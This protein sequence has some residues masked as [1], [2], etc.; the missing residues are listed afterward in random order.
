M[1][2]CIVKFTLGQILYARTGGITV[3]APAK[4]GTLLPLGMLVSNPN[5]PTDGSLQQMTVQTLEELE[6]VILDMNGQVSHDRRPGGNT[7]KRFTVWKWRGELE[8]QFEAF[9]S[10]GIGNLLG[11]RGPREKRGTFFYLR[12][13]YL[14][15]K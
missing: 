1:P 3:V 14:P 15:Q 6:S 2:V 5:P 10:G 4:D 13:A 12:G 8:Q 9:G 7:W 11:P